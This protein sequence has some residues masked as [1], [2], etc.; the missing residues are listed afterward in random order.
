MIIALSVLFLSALWGIAIGIRLILS[1]E[2]RSKTEGL[3][4]AV[5][6]AI[7][8]ALAIEIFVTREVGVNLLLIFACSGVTWWVWGRRMKRRVETEVSR[9]RG[10]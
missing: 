8:A 5:P 1:G 3:M 6:S 4:Y 9:Q 2:A 10:D 7:A